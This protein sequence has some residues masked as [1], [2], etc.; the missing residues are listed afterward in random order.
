MVRNGPMT[1]PKLPLNRRRLMAGLGAAALAPVW[2]SVGHSQARPTALA[3]QA[4]AESVTL[5]P[6][7]PATPVWSLQGPD[8]RYKRG[9]ILDIGFGNELP[10]PAI[11]NW[12]GID[13]VPAAQPLTGGLL[14]LP[15]ARMRCNCRCVTPGP[16]CATSACWET[17]NRIPRGRGR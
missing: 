5:R 4:K 6:N 13:G 8:R 14:S 9:E 1:S 12:R 3:L 7:I 15:A 17:D 11:L 10:A 2:A 16:F